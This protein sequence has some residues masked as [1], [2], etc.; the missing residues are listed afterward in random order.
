[1]R[2]I[3]GGYR[4]QEVDSSPSPSDDHSFI[5]SLSLGPG[6]VLRTG[7]GLGMGRPKF[8]FETGH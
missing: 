4:D 5:H 2:K 3:L 6:G 1:M 7:V 8:N